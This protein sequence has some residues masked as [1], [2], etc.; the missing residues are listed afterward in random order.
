M[1]FL[2]WAQRSRASG[3]NLPTLMKGAFAL[4]EVHKDAK[5]RSGICAEV[6]LIMDA[7]FRRNL[8]F[9]HKSWNRKF[10]ANLTLG[11]FFSKLLYLINITIQLYLLNEFLDELFFENFNIV[12]LRMLTRRKRPDIY[13][14]VNI[15]PLLAKCKFYNNFDVDKVEPKEHL[16]TLP[17]NLYNDRLFFSVALL[18]FAMLIGIMWSSCQWAAMLFL[19][20]FKDSLVKKV[21][22]ED[23]D[24]HHFHRRYRVV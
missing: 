9:P 7:Y 6:A 14:K 11:Y 15:F 16:C 4:T 3:L 1:P 17:L 13:A 2:F 18:L 21:L 10:A 24:M 19:P 20:R 5:E 8:L 12:F 22:K 23:V